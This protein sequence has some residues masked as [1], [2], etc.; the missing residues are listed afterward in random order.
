MLLIEVSQKARGTLHDDKDKRVVCVYSKANK[1]KPSSKQN[2]ETMRLGR[3][4]YGDNRLSKLS[5]RISFC[6]IFPVP[7]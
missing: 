6:A 5:A 1:N 7:H 4:I 3:S 2:N